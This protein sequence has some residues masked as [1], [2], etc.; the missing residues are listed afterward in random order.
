MLAAAERSG[1]RVASS[2]SQFLTLSD[3]CCYHVRDQTKL[4]EGGAEL[5]IGTLFGL[6]WRTRRG[7]RTQATIFATEGPIFSA[8]SPPFST[9]RRS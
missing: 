4:I 8:A 7:K 2:V 1:S 5:S 3:R 9:L 6:I